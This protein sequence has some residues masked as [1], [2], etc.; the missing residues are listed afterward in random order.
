MRPEPTSRR[1]FL[2]RSAALTGAAALGLSSGRPAHAR[3]PAPTVF[4]RLAG[5]GPRYTFALMADPQ[6]GPAAT[7]NRVGNT[8]QLKMSR[9]VD[10]INA[11]SPGPAFVVING[12]LVNTADEPSL[13]NFLARAKPL[14]PTTILVHGNHDGHPPYPEFR[15]CQKELNGTSEVMFSFDAG[16]WHFVTFPCNLSADGSMNEPL[17]A[18]LDADLKAHRDRPTLVFEHLHLLP[19]GLTQLEWYT[20]EKTF[21]TRLL[22]V[23][24]G[25]GNVR[26]VICGHVH[27]GIQAA[28][29]TAWRHRGMNF[30]TAPTCTASRNFGEEFEPFRSGMDQGPGSPDTGGGYYLM[31]DVHGE[32][33]TIRGRVVGVKD[34]H[35]FTNAPREYRDEEPLWFRDLKDW[36]TRPS[37]VNGDFR[38]GLD[39]WL[40]PYRYLTDRDPGFITEVRPVDDGGPAVFL[41]CREKGQPWA[42]DEQV[43]VYQVVAV[44]RGGPVRVRASYRVIEPQREGGGYLRVCGFAGDELKLVALFDWSEGRRDHNDRISQNAIHQATGKHGAPYTLRLMG[45]RRQAM[46]WSLPAGP[47]AWHDIEADLGASFDRASGQ[48]GAFERLGID[49]VLIASGAWCNE[50]PGSRAGT[51]VR[52][53]DVV[54]GGDGP[55][56]TRL[57]GKAL[58]DDA[59]IFQT[60]FGRESWEKSRKPAGA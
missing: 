39:G 30:L 27:N 17:L 3:S 47:G 26:Q 54:R 19:Q 18:W 20:Y 12:D 31:L 45:E 29:K 21:R 38:Q 6:V 13:G 10:E 53:V 34:E 52:G 59:S 46:F 1:E 43:E 35:V 4:P 7:R 44:D 23:M 57:D 22:D 24:A 36:P 32:E 51:L 55:R 37:L 5:V 58:A 28:V 9:I 2:T 60:D 48:A 41:F 40:Q 42:R 25:A 33:L 8:T 14:R 16:P 15:R 50:F 56:G 49:R 11:A